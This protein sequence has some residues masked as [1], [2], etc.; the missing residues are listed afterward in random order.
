[1]KRG[2]KTK[3]LLE[4]L[5]LLI[6]TTSQVKAFE[7]S[8]FEDEDIYR[9]ALPPSPPST[10]ITAPGTK[11]CGPGNTSSSYNDLGTQRETDMCCRDHDHCD[12]ILEA[13]STFRG[14]NNSDWFPILKCSCEQKFINCL[15]AVNNM[16]S[17]TL[18]HVYYSARSLCIAE[19]HPIVSCKQYMEGTFRKRCIRYNVDKKRPKIWQFYEMPF[20]T[21]SSK[22]QLNKTKK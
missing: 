5:I 16:I 1:M 21:E 18:G 19:G 11:W 14:L 15:Q 13:R 3:V 8:I 20:Y 22:K 9:Q 12:D 10:G 7:E 6:F 17:N 2:N 4:L